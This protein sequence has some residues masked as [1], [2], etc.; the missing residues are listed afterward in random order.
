[1]S[2]VLFLICPTDGLE[3]VIRQTFGQNNY[4]LTSL[5]CACHLDQETQTFL[6]NWITKKDI[7]RICIVLS[8]DNKIMLDALA[9]GTYPRL[10]KLK[11]L[12]KEVSDYWEKVFCNP[13]YHFS[14]FSFY[15]SQRISIVQQQFQEFNN[16]IGAKVYSRQEHDFAP[17]EPGY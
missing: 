7:R 13:N 8:E 3:P 5:G 9:G 4:F 2:P 11:P 14:L 16:P 6:K 17:I 10:P 12:Y 1:M 15:L